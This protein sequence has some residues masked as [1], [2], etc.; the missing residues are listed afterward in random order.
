MKHYYTP[1]LNTQVQNA[2]L[3]LIK[4][5]KRMILFQSNPFGIGLLVKVIF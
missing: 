3:L 2:P 4:S 5:N 1:V